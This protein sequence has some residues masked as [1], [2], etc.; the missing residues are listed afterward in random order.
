MEMAQVDRVQGSMTRREQRPDWQ[1]EAVDVDARSASIDARFQSIE[2]RFNAIDRR[3]DGINRRL[4]GLDANV[5]RLFTWL[6]VGLQVATL[7]AIVA[8]LLAR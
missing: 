2:R 4:D 6:I 5:S 3:F 7:T 1:F 8:A